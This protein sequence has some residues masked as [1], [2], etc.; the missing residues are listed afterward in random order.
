MRG[1][2]I[3]DFEGSR[4]IKGARILPHAE[5][6]AL[7]V[8]LEIDE[9]SVAPA[10]LVS[11]ESLGKAYYIEFKGRPASDMD[12]Y[13]GEGYGH[14]GMARGLV[15]VDRVE[16]FHRLPRRTSAMAGSGR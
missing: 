11:E 16:R 7:Q 2:W 10:E 6:G 9:R 15:L 4:F 1:I 5:E 14:M 3:N 13:P 12:R 8:W